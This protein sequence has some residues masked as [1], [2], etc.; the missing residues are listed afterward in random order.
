MIILRILLFPF[1]LLYG[2]I[3]ALRNSAYDLGILRSHTFP[4]PIIAVGN[5]SV[6]GTGKTPQIEQLIRLLQ[7]HYRIATLSR[8]YRRK[9]KGY[10]VANDLTDASSKEAILG[11]EPYQIHRKFPEVTVAV[12]ADRV[13]GITQLLAR[14]PQPELVL[15]DDAFQHRRVKAGFYILLTAYDDLYCDDWMLPSGT[16]REFAS[17]VQRAHMIIITKCPPNLSELA[18]QKIRQRLHA[19]AP[20]FFSTIVYEDGVYDDQKRLEWSS[21]NKSDCVFVTGIEKPKPFL[22]FVGATESQTLRFPDHHSFTPQ[23]IER[24][25]REYLGKIVIT[26]EKDFVRL[27]GKGLQLPLYYL[28]MQSQL[29]HNENQWKQLIEDYVGTST[30]NR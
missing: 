21:V 20:V 28:P 17:G 14:K 3:T 12:D 13:R 16:L 5:L 25:N 29:L 27:H 6:G 22:E 18:Q 30:R 4:V 8:G 10:W 26:T 24:I 7:P 19:S 9:S 2:G 11:D 15:L 23:D 1:A